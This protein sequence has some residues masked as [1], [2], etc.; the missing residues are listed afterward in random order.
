MDATP[1][2]ARIKPLSDDLLTTGRAAKLIA[3]RTGVRASPS[4]VWRWMTGGCHGVRLEHVKIG[5]RVFTTAAALSAF[6]SASSAPPT[7][8]DDDID[9]MEEVAEEHADLDRELAAEGL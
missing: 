8:T 4:T 1:T 2:H 7:R 5:R 6:I 3:K 9:R